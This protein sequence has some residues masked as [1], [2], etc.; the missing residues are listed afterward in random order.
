MMKIQMRLTNAAAVTD[1]A[2]NKVVVA[3]KHQQSGYTELLAS[4]KNIR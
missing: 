4:R 3:E 1:F 2:G